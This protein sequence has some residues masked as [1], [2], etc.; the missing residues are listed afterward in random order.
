M[1]KTWIQKFLVS[2]LILGF[3]LMAHSRVTKEERVLVVIS[4]LDSGGFPELQPLYTILEHLT[5][6]SVVGSMSSEYEEIEVLTNEEATFERFRSVIHKYGNQKGVKAIDVILSLHGLKKRLSWADRRLNV[7]DMEA[8]FLKTATDQEKKKLRFMYNLSCYG[9][10]HNQAFVNMGFD[11]AT[12]SKAINAN[13]EFEF[14]PFLAHWKLGHGFKNSF[15]SSNG[16]IALRMADAP[17][18][19]IGRQ[20]NNSLKYT[21]SKKIFL[22]QTK[23]KIMMDPK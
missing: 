5:G 23:I 11:V 6:F 1:K 18:R 16:P 2:L 4:E 19:W 15:A 13:S 17:V 12:G 22:G 7:S 8:I 14:L 9:K 3:S 21:D 10:T 20:A